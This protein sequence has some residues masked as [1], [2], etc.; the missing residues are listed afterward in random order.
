VWRARD[1]RARAEVAV[2]VLTDRDPASLVRF[3]QEQAVRLRHP[4]VVAPHGWVAEDDTVL[5]V[6]DLVRGESLAALRTARGPLP[7]GQVATVL[8]QALAGLTAVHAAGLVHRDVKPANLLLDTAGPG[9][10]RI[11]LADFGIALPIGAPQPEVAGTDGY[12]A[13]ELAEAGPADPRQDLYALGATGRR[14]RAGTGTACPDGP[15]ADLLATL[16]A[17]DP[18]DRPA[19]A[20]AA[21]RLLHHL[22]G[23]PPAPLPSLGVPTHDVGADRRAAAAWSAYSRL[24]VWPAVWVLLFAVGAAAGWTAAR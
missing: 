22:L 2:K 14:L 15:L 16:A 1:T 4:H 13:P 23:G 17:A 18:A 5:L 12:L 19:D 21:R 11:R 6:M 20:P 7:D 8:D 10:P 3:V 9:P 24:A